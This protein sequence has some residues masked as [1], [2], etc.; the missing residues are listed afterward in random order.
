MSEQITHSDAAPYKNTQTWM[1]GLFMLLFAFFYH[2]A[3]MLLGAVAFIQF[4]WVLATGRRNPQLTDFGGG[5]SRFFYQLVQFLTFNSDTKPFP[6][7][8]WPSEPLPEETPTP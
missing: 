5:L 7:S 8:D 2:L 6:F 3:V 4:V 1:R